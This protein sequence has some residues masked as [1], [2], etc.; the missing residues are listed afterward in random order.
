MHVW[1]DELVRI[2][3]QEKQSGGE[4]K[5]RTLEEPGTAAARAKDEVNGRDIEKY[6][7]SKT[8]VAHEVLMTCSVLLTSSDSVTCEDHV[9]TNGRLGDVG[10]WLALR[11][12]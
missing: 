4:R 10:S 7:G 2:Q 1:P 11:A 9:V 3:E 6:E 5:R 8:A 12:V